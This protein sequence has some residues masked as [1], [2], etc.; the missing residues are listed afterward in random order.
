MYLVNFSVSHEAK[1]SEYWRQGYI[2]SQESETKPTLV[3][4]TSRSTKD[5][6]RGSANY[7]NVEI[8]GGV[9]Y[10]LVVYQ[11]GTER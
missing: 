9:R 2:R 10:H 5:I 6:R 1:S 7:Q 11:S 4:Q 8:V 3:L